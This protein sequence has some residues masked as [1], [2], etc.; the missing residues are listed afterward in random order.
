MMDLRCRTSANPMRY[1][2][3]GWG[4]HCP[5][6]VRRPGHFV[7]V[8]RPRICQV[9][10]LLSDVT[11]C[12][13]TAGTASLAALHAVSFEQAWDA[14]TLS[15]MLAAAGAFAFVHADGFVLARAPADGARILT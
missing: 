7:S 8:P 1:G 12:E 5:R 6:R 14:K 15:D 4:G 10:K 11:P 9:E 13:P 2:W 3:R